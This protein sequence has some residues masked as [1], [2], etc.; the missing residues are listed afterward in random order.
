VVN[1]DGLDRRKREVIVRDSLAA[2]VATLNLD[3]TQTLRCSV[4]L[5]LER[6]RQELLVVL[7]I[8]WRPTEVFTGVRVLQLPEDSA[9]IV[10]GNPRARIDAEYRKTSPLP[11]AGRLAVLT[12]RQEITRRVL[13]LPQ[14]R[15]A[16][17]CSAQLLPRSR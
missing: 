16:R 15:G 3:L 17:R 4:R 6:G 1:A 2:I 5:T 7:E 13:L 8:P 11:L 10:L 14:L 12:G 9:N